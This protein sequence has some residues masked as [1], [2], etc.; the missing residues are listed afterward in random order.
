[1]NGDKQQIEAE[2]LTNLIENSRT[3]NFAGEIIYETT[4][5]VRSNNFQYIDLGDVQGVSELTLNGKLIG[6]RWYGAHIY[7]L[8]NGLKEGDNK[9]TIKVTTI[10]GNYLK[11][12]KDNVVA[13]NWTRHQEYYP[14]GLIGPVRIN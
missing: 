1:M 10:T 3:R 13:Q 6:T 2:S 8:K 9:L 5:N 14:M 11:S 4:I 7:Y 12:L